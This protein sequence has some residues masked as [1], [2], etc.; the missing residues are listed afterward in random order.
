[1]CGKPKEE[2]CIIG[3]KHGKKNQL[4]SCQNFLMARI[5]LLCHLVHEMYIMILVTLGRWILS[6]M[7]VFIYE[8]KVRVEQR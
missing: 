5:N 1:M 8:I 4:I 6:V 2:L 3:K 7:N